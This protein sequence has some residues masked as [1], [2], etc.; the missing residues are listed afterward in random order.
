MAAIDIFTKTPSANSRHNPRSLVV[1]LAA[2]LVSPVRRS[3]PSRLPPRW[4][5][6][7]RLPCASPELPRPTPPPRCFP[8]LVPLLVPHGEPREGEGSIFFLDLLSDGG[9]R[10]SPSLASRSCPFP[11]S[12]CSPRR[13]LPSRTIPSHSAATPSLE[14]PFPPNPKPPVGATPQH[15]PSPLF[16]G[17]GLWPRRSLSLSPSSSRSNGLVHKSG[18]T[19]RSSLFR[20]SP[21]TTTAPPH[22]H[23]T[24]AQVLCKSA[25]AD[26]VFLGGRGFGTAMSSL[27]LTV[28]E[29]RVWLYFCLGKYFGMEYIVALKSFLKQ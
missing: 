21:S 14:Q 8:L 4:S 20:S 1:S 28:L 24:R 13:L 5:S 9:G 7:A 3:P 25:L 15:A 12:I 27:I 2:S 18:S 26:T 10:P 22:A 6:P 23:R 16:L 17:T 29:F 11:L 19:S